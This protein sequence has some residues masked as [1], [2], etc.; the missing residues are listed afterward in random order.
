L[1]R[2]FA[3]VT[4]IAFSLVALFAIG[5]LLV[6]GPLD[7]LLI[8]RWFKQALA[9]WITFPVIVLL[10]GGL[11]LGLAERRHGGG[12]L[13][14]NQLELVDVDMSSGQARGT[15]WSAV[16][17]PTAARLDLRLDVELLGDGPGAA[18]VR[19]HSW[20]LPGTGIGGT[21]SAG[22]NLWTEDA[23]HF[24][25]G[26][27][28][29]VGVPILTSGTKSLLGCWTAPAEA[30]VRAELTN[31]DGWV[32]GSLE[33]HTGRTLRNVRLYFG[34]WG[35]R[36]GTLANGARI[37]VSE[38]LRPRSFKTII[39]QDSLGASDRNQTEEQVFVA[40]RASLREILNVMMFYDAVGGFNFAQLQ[41]RLQANCDL[42]R[43]PMLGRA[44]LVADV[45]TRGSR[46]VDPESGAAIGEQDAGGVT[47]RFVLP[48][49]SE[50]GL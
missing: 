23:Y 32:T 10:F 37:D 47:Y 14:V 33:N 19:L 8:Q 26:H 43:F 6:L 13:R 30:L 31:E 40:E 21:Q 39:T 24:R 25:D 1:G 3:G 35:C 5:Y 15:V 36:L 44:L 29:L 42:S 38:D 9:A 20:A 41:N 46:L 16:Y 11:A 27:R 48:V 17:S 22:K 28:E 34:E 50:K 18:E 2:S 4:P 45:E 12:G 7:Y 49:R